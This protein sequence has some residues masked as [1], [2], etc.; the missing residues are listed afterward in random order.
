VLLGVGVLAVWATPSGSRSTAAAPKIEVTSS[1]GGSNAFVR[2]P[3]LYTGLLYGVSGALLAAAMSWTAL[4]LLDAPVARLAPQLRQ[5]L[6]A[7]FPRVGGAGILLGAGGLLAYSV[8]GWRP[9]RHLARI[10]TRA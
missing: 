4:E 7:A 3:F 8:P 2:R 10:G 5:Q 9:A 1:F 6:P